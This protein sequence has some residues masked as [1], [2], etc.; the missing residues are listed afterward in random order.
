MNSPQTITG[1]NGLTMVA[2]FKAQISFNHLSGQGVEL[3]TLHNPL[4]VGPKKA[5]VY[6]LIG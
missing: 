4:P 6:M 5:R 3:G 1:L 2:E